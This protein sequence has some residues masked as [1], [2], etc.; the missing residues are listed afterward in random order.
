MSALSI[1]ELASQTDT[2]VATIRY[3]ESIGLL[4]QPDRGSG[5]QRRYGSGD[6]TRLEFIRTRRSL[7]FSLKMIGQ[8]LK[9]RG[10][11]GTGLDL[12]RAQLTRIERQ[13]AILRSAAADLL[14]QITVC[15]QGCATGATPPCL[16]LPAA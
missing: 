11:C 4:P 10:D 13:I 2:P 8:L 6:R 12:A 5:G 16:I 7:G 3:Y 9:Q 15:E 1:G 14:Q